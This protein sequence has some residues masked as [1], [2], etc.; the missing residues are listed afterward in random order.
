MFVSLVERESGQ[1]G[2]GNFG[3]ISI[4]SKISTLL[5]TLNRGAKRLTNLLEGL[6]GGRDKNWKY[7][8]EDETGNGIINYLRHEHTTQ[9]TTNQTLTTANDRG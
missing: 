5:A 9:M 6:W 3:W 1:G 8:C 7:L 4:S 2:L